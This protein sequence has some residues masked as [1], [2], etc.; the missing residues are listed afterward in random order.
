MGFTN[1]V[2]LLTGIA[3]FLFGMTLMGDGLKRVAGSSLE[4]VLYRLSG[5]PLK[6]IILGTGVTAVIQSSSATSIMVVGFV[7]SGMMK[8]KQAIGIIMGAIIGTSFTGWI[9]CL[10]AIGGGGIFEIISTATLTALIAVIGIILKMFTGSE[11][12]HYLG[13]IMLGFAVLMFGIST[14]SGSVE[15]LRESPEFISMMT[16]FTNP[17]LGILVGL[18][19]TSIIQ[20]AS[21]AV[22]ILQALAVTGAI[23][24]Q[25]ALPVIMGIAIGAAVP[26]LLSALGATVSG[27]RTAFIYLMVDT[28]GVIIFSILFYTANAVFGFSFMTVTMNMVM[29][30]LLNT[31]FRAVIVVIQAPFIGVLEKL[32]KHVIKDNTEVVEELKDVDRLEERFLDYPAL[33]IEQTRITI[34]TMA[35]LTEKNVRDARKLL[36]AYSEEGMNKVREIEKIIDTY[37]DKLGAYLVRIMRK[38]LSEDQNRTMNEYLHVITDFERISDHALNLGEC[39]EELAQKKIKF[40]PEAVRE[41][42]ILLSAVEEVL[43][44]AVHAFTENDMEAAY[45]IE[46]LEETIDNLCDEMKLRHVERIRTGVCRYAHGFAFNDI[47]TNCERIGDHCSNIGIAIKVDIE[48]ID[49]HDS[50]NRMEIE[51]AHGFDEMFAEYN[52]KYEI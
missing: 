1:I 27:K 17:F 26:V 14:M 34:N 47:L 29:I 40:T 15:P 43:A 35:G 28:M 44:L 23:N 50:R 39:A 49:A 30:A 41:L 33:S 25:L 2:T 52:V 46:P 11:T 19:F 4:L 6:G 32:V 38:E 5:T 51:R 16:S 7:N 9:I 18:L 12:K 37:E 20:S 36:T 48:G 3:L 24:F 8:V 10:S 21:A 22:G 45:R 13:D 42:K 31:V